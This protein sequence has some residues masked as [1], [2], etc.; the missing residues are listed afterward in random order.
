MVQVTVAV[1]VM[2][3]VGVEVDVG[4]LGVLV[5]VNVEVTVEVAV[6]ASVVLVEVVV[7]V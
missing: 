7:A 1:P 5:E 3:K 2:A 4:A 6:D